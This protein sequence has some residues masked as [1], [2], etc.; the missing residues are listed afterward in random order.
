[1]RRRKRRG[2]CTAAFGSTLLLSITLIANKEMPEGVG[3]T[4]PWRRE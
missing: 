2:R 1:M 3:V 4:L